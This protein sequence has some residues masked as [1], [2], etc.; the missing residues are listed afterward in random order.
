MAVSHSKLYSK[1]PEGIQIHGCWQLHHGDVLL[2]R[3][4]ARSLA[5]GVAKP[6][7]AWEQMKPCDEAPCWKHG[8]AYP[9]NATRNYNM[10]GSWNRGTTKS[11]TLMGFSIINHPA[12]GVPIM[13]TPHDCG[14][15]ECILE[16]CHSQCWGHRYPK[17]WNWYA[18]LTTARPSESR[19]SLLGKHENTSTYNFYGW[20]N[21]Q[22]S[23]FWWFS[24]VETRSVG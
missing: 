19:F 5:V 15:S 12:M 6:L 22:G 23:R 10:G 13:E 18:T 11:S 8:C 14:H 24:I 4:L 7:N 16:H 20:V 2:N 17:M 1:L 21:Y 3:E 9:K